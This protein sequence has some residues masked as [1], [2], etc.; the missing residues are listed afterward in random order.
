M[1]CSVCLEHK[2][3]DQFF[4]FRCKHSVCKTCYKSLQDKNRCFYCRQDIM[5]KELCIRLDH[6]FFFYLAFI[7]LDLFY[8]SIVFILFTNSKSLFV[9]LFYSEMVYGSLLI[10]LLNCFYFDK[11]PILYTF[12]MLLIKIGWIVLVCVMEKQVW[13]MIVLSISKLCLIYVICGF[14]YVRYK[15]RLSFF[16]KT[17]EMEDV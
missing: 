12:V 5:D 1:E 13:K 7:L 8:T 15:I 9:I 10:I 6:I 3:T 4:T 17:I 16:N 14:E 2:K 11:P